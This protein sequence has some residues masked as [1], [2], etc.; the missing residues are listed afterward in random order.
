V[1]TDYSNGGHAGWAMAPLLKVT[2]FWEL[3]QYRMA[4]LLLM[5]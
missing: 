2:V 5:L 1:N 3:V 4:L